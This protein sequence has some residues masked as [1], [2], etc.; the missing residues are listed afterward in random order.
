[1]E[2]MLS[3]QCPPLTDGKRETER[4]E[5]RFRRYY[6][7]FLGALCSVV[8]KTMAAYS[9]KIRTSNRMQDFTSW[10]IAAEEA[11]G[12]KNGEFLKAYRA[13]QEELR[14]NALETPI[15]AQLLEWRSQSNMTRDWTGT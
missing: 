10:A 11:L 2:R 5:R 8:S 4:T 7:F 13:N 15:I 9:V 1:M 14:Y 12:Y 3:I 6:P